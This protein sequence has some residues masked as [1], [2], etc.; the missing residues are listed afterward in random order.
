ME[1]HAL[2]FPINYGITLPSKGDLGS[3]MRTQRRVNSFFTKPCRNINLLL[4]FKYYFLKYFIPLDN[5]NMQN[6]FM[7]KW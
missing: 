1:D 7:F 3:M 5:T 2:L 4:Y 6:P